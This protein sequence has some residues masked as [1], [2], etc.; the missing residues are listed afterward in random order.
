MSAFGLRG[1][2]FQS[3]DQGWV[4]KAESVSKASRQEPDKMIIRTVGAITALAMDVGIAELLDS[5][6]AAGG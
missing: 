5:A 3:L 6:V 2:F 4:L 1:A